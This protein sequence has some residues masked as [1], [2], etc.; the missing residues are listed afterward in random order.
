MNG[1]LRIP[2]TVPEISNPNF[3]KSRKAPLRLPATRESAKSP[4]RNRLTRD[5]FAQH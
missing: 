3:Y 5:C 4:L 2:A 1:K